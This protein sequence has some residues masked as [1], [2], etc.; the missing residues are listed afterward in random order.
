MAVDQV[1]SAVHGDLSHDDP[2]KIKDENFFSFFN[3]TRICQD[4]PTYYVV[5]VSTNKFLKLCQILNTS[6]DSLPLVHLHK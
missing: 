1:L 5:V 2:S 3:F 4:N 6:S